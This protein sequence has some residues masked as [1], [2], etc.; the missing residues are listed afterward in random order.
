V[1]SAVE[2]PPPAD[3]P[4]NPL[5]RTDHGSTVI[6]SSTRV[7]GGGDD[8]AARTSVNGIDGS[9]TSL[10][11]ELGLTAWTVPAVVIGVPGFVLIAAVLLQVAGGAAWVAIADRSLAGIGLRRRVR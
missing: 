2:P 10:F 11:L 8:D 4:P 5:E 7:A 1:L 6:T 3:P 9:V